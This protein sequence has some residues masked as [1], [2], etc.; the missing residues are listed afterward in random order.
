MDNSLLEKAYGMALASYAV[1]AALKDT[2]IVSDDLKR[3]FAA[4]LE[5]QSDLF[6]EVSPNMKAQYLQLL[7]HLKA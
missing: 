6:A 5:K 2:V 3:A 1:V 7:E 4:N